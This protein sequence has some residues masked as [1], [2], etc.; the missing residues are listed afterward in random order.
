MTTFRLSAFADEAASD[1]SAQLAELKKH[2]IDLLEIRGVDGKSMSKLTDE[3]ARSAKQ[4]MD[5]AGIGLSALGSP[6]G[7]YP[8]EADFAAHR[9]DFRRGRRR[10]EALKIVFQVSRICHFSLL[11]FSFNA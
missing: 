5:D 4:M 6:Y 10:D 7:K 2:G 9:D 3:E 11:P 8:I 1:F